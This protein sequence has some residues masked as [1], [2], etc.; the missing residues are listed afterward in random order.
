MV[1]QWIGT[2]VIGGGEKTAQ[3]EDIDTRRKIGDVAGFR[4]DVVELENIRTGASGERVGAESRNQNI[5]SG[6][7]VHRRGVVVSRQDIVQRIA[8]RRLS[9]G[10][11]QLYV[12]DI[13]RQH[14]TRLLA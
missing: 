6:A 8:C 12:L 11:D 2:L 4:R 9:N 5:V 10:A 3:I 1:D 7:A 13:G 14:I